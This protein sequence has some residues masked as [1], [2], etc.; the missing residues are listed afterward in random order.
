MDLRYM[1]FALVDREFYDQPS[2]RTPN[3]RQFNPDLALDWSMWDS[4][5]SD[6][7]IGWHP[8][9]VMLP[10]QG[11]KIHTSATTNNAQEM[12]TVI[13]RYCHEHT[14]SFKHVPS[15]AEMLQRNMKYVDRGA[16]GKWLIVIESVEPV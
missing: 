4:A 14:L 16:S 6:G 13:S 2:E 3:R 7:W 1:E 15:Q 12:L 10:D 11:W 8:S 9:G 5:E